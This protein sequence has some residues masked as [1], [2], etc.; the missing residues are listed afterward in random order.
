MRCP[1]C[2]DDDAALNPLDEALA[3]PPEVVYDTWYAQTSLDCLAWLLNGSEGFA[4]FW[5]S[6]ALQVIR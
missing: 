6:V 2:Y 5:Q 1:R 3:Q 4:F